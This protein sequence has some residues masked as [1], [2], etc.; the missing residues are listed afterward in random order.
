MTLQNNIFDNV[1]ETIPAEL[2]QTL[3]NTDNIRIERIVSHG[4]ASPEHFW[5]DQSE[6]E[7][8][9]LIK[10]AARIQFEGDEPVD[11][12]PGSFMNIPAHQRHRVDWTEPNEPTIW[13]AIY[14]S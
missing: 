9:L 11:L 1:P 4:H 10:G 6:H 13:L 8:V 12:I 3:L 7:W 14:Y 2:L 5:Y